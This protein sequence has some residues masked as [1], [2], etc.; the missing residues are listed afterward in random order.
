M[1]YRRNIQ[2]LVTNPVKIGMLYAVLG[3]R[4]I[5][6][7]PWIGPGRYGHFLSSAPVPKPHPYGQ[8]RVGTNQ[9][10]AQMA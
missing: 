5:Q 8:G 2:Q 7:S 1:G 10:Y 4:G 3:T 9:R 6:R